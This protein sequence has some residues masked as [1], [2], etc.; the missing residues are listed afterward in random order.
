M[1]ET[2]TPLLTAYVEQLDPASLP[3]LATVLA[4]AITHLDTVATHVDAHRLDT[5]DP[6]ERADLA[7]LHDLV[8]EGWAKAATAAR[9][10]ATLVDVNGA[11]DGAVPAPEVECTNDV[12]PCAVPALCVAP[13]EPTPTGRTGDGHA[14]SCPITCDGC[15]CSAAGA[16]WHHR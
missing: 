4:E 9:V 1:T 6:D 13:C 8:A 15:W 12:A 5:D 14:A 7:H 3:E 11:L 2:R 16:C 10:L